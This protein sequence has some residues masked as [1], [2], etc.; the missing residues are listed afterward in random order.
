MSRSKS[1]MSRETT[2]LRAA[3]ETDVGFL[4]SLR[5]DLALQSQLLSIPRANSMTKVRQ[6]LSGIETDERSVFFVIHSN[7]GD[8]AIGFI[9][10]R[11]ICTI[12]RRG[13]LGICITEDARGEGYGS[14]AI[15]MVEDYCS[16]VFGLRK[17][18]LHALA[19]NDSAVR[20][21]VKLG[22]EKAGIHRDHFYHDGAFHDVVIMEKLFNQSVPI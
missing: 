6:W 2:F 18:T 10:V 20:L 15:L 19:T 8:G 22:Y 13:S 17:L 4:H 1:F 5:N 14:N 9:Q 21:Y 3:E 7:S 11:E 12:H 16:R